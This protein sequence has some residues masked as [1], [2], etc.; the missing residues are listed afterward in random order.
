MYVRVS[1]QQKRARALVWLVSVHVGV[2]NCMHFVCSIIE[3]KN[4]L[5]CVCV[6]VC[7]CVSLPKNMVTA[8]RN[9]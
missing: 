6:R 1:Q 8:F 7:A 4:V 3:Y 2:I 5:I 9:V